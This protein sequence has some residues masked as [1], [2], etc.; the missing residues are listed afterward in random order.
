M[1]MMRQLVAAEINQLDEDE[2]EVVMST[3]VLARDGHILM[4]GGCVLDNYRANPI[5]LWSHN[6]D[7]PI[8][9]APEIV[10]EADKIRARIRFAPLGISAK[11]DEVRGLMKSGV[12]RAVSVGFN[13]IDGEALNPAKPRGG[14]RFTSWELLELSAVSVPSDPDALVTARANGD[15]AMPETAPVT[16]DAH[17]QNRTGHIRAVIIPTGQRGLYQVAQLASILG[18]LGWQIDLAK[19][20]AN[21]EGDGSQVPTM[22]ADALYA[23]GDA[24]LAMAAEE[25]SELFDSVSE[26]LTEADEIDEELLEESER[27]HV[28][29]GTTPRVRAWRRAFA[30]AKVRAGKKISSET[31]RCLREARALHDEAMDLHRSAIRKH[32]EGLQSIDDLMERSGVSDPEDTESQTVQTSNG[33][34]ESDGSSNGRSALQPPVSAQANANSAS[35]E[36]RQRQADVLALSTTR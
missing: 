29:A 13:P 28:R 8:G 24:F 21:C 34:D 12:V 16:R 17:A 7:L 32:K 10:V 19:W 4:P 35:Y 1:T 31:A 26:G 18:E 9:N 2:I 36:Y 5:V 14:Q 20:E 11:A 15:T 6:P 25:V 23:L 33:T 30:V 27:A 22:L 3:A